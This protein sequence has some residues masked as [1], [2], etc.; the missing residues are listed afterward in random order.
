M[1]RCHKTSQRTWTWRPPR[2]WKP[3]Q[4]LVAQEHDVPREG[5]GFQTNRTFS[6]WSGP[7]PGKGLER[8]GAVDCDVFRSGHQVD[9]SAL[10]LSHRDKLQ[11]FYH[12]LSGEA[13]TVT[14]LFLHLCGVSRANK[15]SISISE[16]PVLE[17]S[18]RD[19]ESLVKRPQKPSGAS[20]R[21]STFAE[22]LWVHWVYRVVE[23]QINQ[24][25]RALAGLAK[26]LSS[27]LGSTVVQNCL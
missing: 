10:L 20:H 27:V 6:K 18:H 7:V 19:V 21:D 9:Q 14:R 3:C 15:G 23:E 2:V 4:T 1:R 25:P 22:G 17:H 12:F 5:V 26:D 13:P 16:H 8:G 11:R 24:P